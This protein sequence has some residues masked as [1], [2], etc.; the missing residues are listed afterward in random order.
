MQRLLSIE[1]ALLHDVLR[2]ADLFLLTGLKTLCA[3]YITQHVTTDN[4]FELYRTAVLYELPRLEES[5]TLH[6]AL[7]VEE[8]VRAPEFAALMRESAATI[9]DRQGVDSLPLADEMRSH[10]AAAYGARYQLNPGEEL[11]EYEEARAATLRYKRGLIDALLAQLGIG[12]LNRLG[13]S[14]E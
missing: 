7:H 12:A 10:L 1:S 14:T 11:D 5:T 3:T 8:V 2:V 6:M 13:R 4:V 9:R